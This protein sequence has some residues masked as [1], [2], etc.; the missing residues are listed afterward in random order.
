MSLVLQ[1]VRVIVVFRE[2]MEVPFVSVRPELIR[3]TQI[4]LHEVTR[5]PLLQPVVL[6]ENV[7]RSPVF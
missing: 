4:I 2:V 5:S 3:Q 1:T 6:L 7:N